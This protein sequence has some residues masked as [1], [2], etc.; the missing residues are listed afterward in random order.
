[1][2]TKNSHIVVR[3]TTPQTYIR[4]IVITM[5]PRR[6]GRIFEMPL[7]KASTVRGL[8]RIESRAA[9]RSREDN[10]SSRFILQ[11]S[12]YTAEAV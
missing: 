11:R 2:N 3:Q 10:I 12:G 7:V 6:G 1:M 8:V 4:Q 5:F 9:E